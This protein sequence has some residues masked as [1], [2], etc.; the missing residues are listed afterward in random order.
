MCVTSGQVQ[1]L[2]SKDW[3]GCVNQTSNVMELE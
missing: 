3:F 2:T 1:L